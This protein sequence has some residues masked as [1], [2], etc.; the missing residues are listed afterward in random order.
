MANLSNI[1]SERYAPEFE[2]TMTNYV[3]STFGVTRREQNLE[4]GEIIIYTNNAAF[5]N[6]TSTLFC[7]VADA[8]G[9]VVIEAWGAGGSSSGGCCCGTTMP[10][11]P[12]AYAKKTLNVIPGDIITGNPGAACGNPSTNCCRGTGIPTCVVIL[13][14]GDCMCMCVESG[15][16][17][18]WACGTGTS[19]FCCIGVGRSN[20]ATECGPGF[21]WI[22]NT[23]PG[24][25]V[26]YGGDIN[27]NGGFTCTYQC[28]ATGSAVA[29]AFMT[30]VIPHAPGLISD[31][32]GKII[33]RAGDLGSA[34]NEHHS[35]A[36]Y[37][38]AIIGAARQQL[39]TIPEFNCYNT[40]DCNCYD[41]SGCYA[42]APPSFP[43]IGS[44]TSGGRQAHGDRGGV[45]LVK[46]KF[47]RD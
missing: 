19:G 18:V 16:T 5:P 25:A 42:K 38:S 44:Y 6:D 23:A 45:G 46:I 7:W 28:A 4:E 20:C 34:S 12:G 27:Y 36:A 35:T 26:A 37:Y 17:G 41:Y 13:A 33:F 21:G 24:D 15:G 3:N 47:M 8:P 2:T 39:N 30:Y 22:C 14:G 29:G 9:K 31:G 1:L 10:G 32:P 40:L 11:N 43:G